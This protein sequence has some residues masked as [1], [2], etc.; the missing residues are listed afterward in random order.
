LNL[1]H[2]LIRY[3]IHHL[4][5]RLARAI[6][7]GNLSIIVHT[8]CTSLP[9]L[10][11]PS[12]VQQL[13]ARSCFQTALKN[14]AITILILVPGFSLPLQESG[15]SLPV[16]TNVLSPGGGLTHSR[17]DSQYLCPYTDE[18]AKLVTN[19]IRNLASRRYVREMIRG[20][21]FDD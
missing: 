14:V 11:P 9:R 13:C 2:Y 16:K 1:I 20:Y 21:D 7:D 12:G 8:P 5:H 10:L 19:V 15:S 3:L 17:I 18:I 6:Y 4:I